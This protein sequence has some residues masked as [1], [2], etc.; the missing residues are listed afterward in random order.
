MTNRLCITTHA[1]TLQDS[2]AWETE[3]CMKLLFFINPELRFKL[4][5]Y[6][7]HSKVHHNSTL[8]TPKQCENSPAQSTTRRNVTQH[9]VIQR[10]VMQHDTAWRSARVACPTNSRE[11]HKALGNFCMVLLSLRCCHSPQTNRAHASCCVLFVWKGTVN[12]LGLL[13]RNRLSKQHKRSGA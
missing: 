1:C 5:P 10:H 12:P 6:D 11:Q 13:V 2:F 4:P 3:F 9:P 7:T 8:F